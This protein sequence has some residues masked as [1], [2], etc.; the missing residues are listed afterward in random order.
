MNWNETYGPDWNKPTFIT[1]QT[2]TGG[3]AIDWDTM[4][5]N[6]SGYLFGNKPSALPKQ[7][8]SKAS[9]AATSGAAIGQATNP[10]AAPQ[11]RDMT[12][13]EMTSQAMKGVKNPMYGAIPAID[14]RMTERGLVRGADGVWTPSEELQNSLNAHHKNLSSIEDERL[15]KYNQS[16]RERQAEFWSGVERSDAADARTRRAY[17]EK[18]LSNYIS[19]GEIDKANAVS[20]ALGHV[21]ALQPDYTK[22]LGLP[23]EQQLKLAQAGM[24]GAQSQNQLAEAQARL[25]AIPYIGPKAEAEIAWH[26]GQGQYY[27]GKNKADLG[28]ARAKAMADMLAGRGKQAPKALTASDW[29]SLSKLKMTDP[30]MYEEAVRNLGLKG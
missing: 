23:Q 28:S 1:K 20:Q 8:Y 21:G 30:V 12:S 6:T 10:I 19:R 3:T 26:K 11:R 9:T 24:Y 22:G 4:R 13:E 18:D 14:M 29:E 16:E 25:A 5:Q 27:G 7:Q 15:A 17:L 2:P